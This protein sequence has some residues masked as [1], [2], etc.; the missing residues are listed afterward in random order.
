MDS[1]RHQVIHALRALTVNLDLLAARFAKRSS[2]HPTDVR[3]LIALLDAA[4]AGEQATPTWVYQHLGLNSATVTAALD[5]LESRGLIERGAD[6]DDRRKVALHVTESAM[7]LGETFFGP[8]IDRSLDTL[9]TFS[10]EQVITIRAFLDAMSSA[11]TTMP[12][13]EDAANHDVD[14]AHDADRTTR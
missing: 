11:V 4:R 8:L 10:D 6:P 5:R 12:D 13:T 1:D 2:L 3:T 14:T 7:D 9:D